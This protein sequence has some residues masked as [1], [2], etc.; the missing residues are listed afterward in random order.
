MRLSNPFGERLGDFETHKTPPK[1]NK[2]ILAIT[3]PFLLLVVQK[4]FDPW[5]IVA[6]R[7][8]PSVVIE[9]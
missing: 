9:R 3:C 4:S 7:Q 2:K 8:T 6:Q 5:T 1:A